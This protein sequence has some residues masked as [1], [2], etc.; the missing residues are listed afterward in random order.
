MRIAA[1]QSM[2]ACMRVE[3]LT[4]FTSSKFQLN[5]NRFYQV[6]KSDLTAIWRVSLAGN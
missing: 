3:F 6:Q 5:T 1:N 4:L 2:F